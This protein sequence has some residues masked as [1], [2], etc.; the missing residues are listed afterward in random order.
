MRGD[1]IVIHADQYKEIFF[2]KIGITRDTPEFQGYIT[3]MAQ[4]AYYMET[5]DG[6]IEFVFDYMSDTHFLEVLEAHRKFKVICPFP[7]VRE[8][9]GADPIRGDDKVILPLQAADLWVGLMR[10]SYEGDKAAQRLLKKIEI[11]DTCT[12]LDEPTLLKHWN[13][14]VSQIP[15]LAD[16]TIE[17]RAAINAWIAIEDEAEWAMQD[18]KEI[19]APIRRN[20]DID[21][22]GAMEGF[23]EERR[24]IVRGDRD[25]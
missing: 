2:E 22:R 17:P 11:T 3:I 14:S 24:V 12:V 8:R 21:L 13:R 20:I 16:L 6:K 10:R 9:F 25:W 7:A 5:S 19:P 1:L 18:E 15:D 23:S 4:V